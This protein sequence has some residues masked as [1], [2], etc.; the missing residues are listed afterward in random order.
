MTAIYQSI[1]AAESCD[2][3]N[4]GARPNLAQPVP[5]ST[6]RG[7]WICFQAF[8]DRKGIQLKSQA[9]PCSVRPGSGESFEGAST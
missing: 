3:G 7:S 4:S 8:G 6:R 9:G 1:T 5:R 2:D